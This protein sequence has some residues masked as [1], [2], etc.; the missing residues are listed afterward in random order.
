MRLQPFPRGTAEALSGRAP[1]LRLQAFPGTKR[2]DPLFDAIPTRHTNKRAYETNRSVASRDLDA[3]AR[4]ASIPGCKLE[5]ITD[6]RKVAALAALCRD[7]MAVDV[8][9]RAR[10]EETA[11]WFRF[12][13]EEL[14]QKRDGFGIGQSGVG[15][16]SKWMAETFFLSRDSAAN[17]E[18]SFSRKSVE[19]TWEQASSASAFALLTTSDNTREAQFAAGRS[20]VR[21]QLA[22]EARGIRTQPFSQL[23]Q[24]YAAMLPLRR[25]LDAALGIPGSTTPQMLFRLGFAE[26]TVRSPRRSVAALLERAAQRPNAAADAG[27]R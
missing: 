13:D 20:Y 16:F 5:L 1:V 10:N 25:Q 9:D 6:V 2:P 4:A 15:G 7:G 22:A 8:S 14:A 18:G 12:D 23:L 26:P 11:A 21:A 24:E 17:P 27:G 19:L 3:I